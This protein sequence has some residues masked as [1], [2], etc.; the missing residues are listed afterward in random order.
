MWRQAEAKAVELRL[1]LN[2]MGLD[3]MRLSEKQKRDAVLAYQLLGD[4]ASLLDAVRFYLSDIR[5]LA[6]GLNQR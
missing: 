5:S 2:K 6:I 3:A 1:D 4:S